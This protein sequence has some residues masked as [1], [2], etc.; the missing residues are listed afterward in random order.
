MRPTH[1]TR[2]RFLSE[3]AWIGAAAAAMRVAGGAQAANAPPD[4]LPSIR[5]GKLEVSRLILGTNQFWGNAHRPGAIGK[6]MKAYYTDER[7]VQVLDA[8][9]EAGVTAVVAGPFPR[10]LE[11]Y[12]KYLKRGGKCRIWI[13]QPN[14][15]PEKMK[16]A[17]TTCAQAGA[18][19]AFIQGVRGDEQFAAGGF[20]V[21]RGWLEHIH[22]FQMPAGI[23]SH[24][25]D[26]HLEYERRKLPTDFYFQC[27]FRPEQYLPEHRA[28][29][30][31]AVRK[32]DK[33][34]VGYKILAA[35]R[36]PAKQA[37]AF[38][39]QHLRA[40]D[41][42]CVGIYPPEN[43]H[44]IQEDAQLTRSL[45]QGAARDARDAQAAKPQ[46]PEPGPA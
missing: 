10:W 24:R 27:F 23:A 21:L 22:S 26:T 2:R 28:A 33:P 6:Q 25:S 14:W 31:A 32:I 16:D 8:V 18:K 13:A 4:K 37:F 3:T 36:L 29:A 45:S 5:L 44:M 20:E 15:S 35:G 41:G 9:G 12:P 43:P 19:A 46:S 40:K 30:V 42:V 7:I 38:A 17:I 34:C 11:L 1:I 39:F